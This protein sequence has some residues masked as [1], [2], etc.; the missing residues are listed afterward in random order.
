[1]GQFI[2]ASLII[3]LFMVLSHTL[4]SL[5]FLLMIVPAQIKFPGTTLIRFQLTFLLTLETLLVCLQ[6]LL[7]L[8]KFLSLWWVT[9][10]SVTGRQYNTA[11]KGQQEDTDTGYTM[12]KYATNNWGHVSLC[13]PSTGG[14]F[15]VMYLS[16][17]VHNEVLSSLNI[18]IVQ[19]FI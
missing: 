8:H 4:I 2:T 9:T 15:D 5:P 13:V 7:S 10:K 11:V 14:F 18:V 1:M 12:E 6:P 3:F 19:P 16:E 17:E